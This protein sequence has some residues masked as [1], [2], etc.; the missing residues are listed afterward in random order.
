MTMFD[1]ILLWIAVIA[2]TGASVTYYPLPQIAA[3][4]AILLDVAP[5]LIMTN[6]Q[7]DGFIPPPA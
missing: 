5:D 6:Y 7:A 1:W 3:L 2:W 4:K